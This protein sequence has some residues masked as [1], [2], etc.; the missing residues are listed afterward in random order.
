MKKRSTGCYNNLQ[1]L[2]AFDTRSF[3]FRFSCT[4]LHGWPLSSQGSKRPQT[5]MAW[6]VMS[7]CLSWASN[8]L[9]SDLFHVSLVRTRRHKHTALQGPGDLRSGAGSAS[10]LRRSG[11]AARCWLEWTVRDEAGALP[12]FSLTNETTDSLSGTW[13]CLKGGKVFVLF[14]GGF[15]WTA[16]YPHRSIII[17]LVEVKTSSI[18]FFLKTMLPFGLFIN[19]IP[20]WGFPVSRHTRQRHS[21]I[22]FPEVSFVKTKCFIRWSS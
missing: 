10:L 5:V 15:C 13:I 14:F 7:L 19:W 2:V 18:F 11:S 4:D 3:S 16:V 21:L 20:V 1:V 22:L 12:S 17:Q 9:I 6:T 8:R